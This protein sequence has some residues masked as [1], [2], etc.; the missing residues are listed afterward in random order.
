MNIQKTSEHFE[1]TTFSLYGLSEP[2]HLINRNASVISHLP[3]RTSQASINS[4]S[5]TRPAAI[6]ADLYCTR[7]SLEHMSGR[8]ALVSFGV[9]A[10]S[11]L[12]SL[13]FVLVHRSHGLL[14]A[15]DAGLTLLT[16]ALCAVHCALPVLTI[17]SSR[18]GDSVLS[19]QLS[20]NCLSFRP[21]YFGDTLAGAVN[22]QI[23]FVISIYKTRNSG[24]FGH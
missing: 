9:A 18:T 7:F 15:S 23:C 2:I 8:V 19:Y 4:T 14:R 22:E 12:A 21:L 17:T 11:L 5:A 20:L 6:T 1:V 10:V 24:T 16:L 3:T 13:V